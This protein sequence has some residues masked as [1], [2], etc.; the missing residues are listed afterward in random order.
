MTRL[1]FESSC[2][3]V[4]GPPHAHALT[5]AHAPSHAPPRP[6]RWGPHGGDAARARAGAMKVGAQKAGGAGPGPGP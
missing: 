6:P 1:R 5:Q 2:A 3:D 4:A